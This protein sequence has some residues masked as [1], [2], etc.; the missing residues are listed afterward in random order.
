MTPNNADS[1]GAYRKTQIEGASPEEI[2]LQLM[3]A[4]VRHAKQAQARGA[5]GDAASA[6]EHALRVLDI[7]NE[8]DNT[9]D[10]EQGA[11]IVDEL[12]AIYAFLQRE[13]SDANIKGE[14]ERFTGVADILRNLYEGWK[15]AVKQFQAGEEAADS[16]SAASERV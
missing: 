7:V 9:L 11:E 4:A 12:E 5:Q 8:L 3:E 15:D 10:R 1:L 6:R 14:F 13:I 16:P 2:L